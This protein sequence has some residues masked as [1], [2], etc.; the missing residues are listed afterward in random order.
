MFVLS[1]LITALASILAIVLNI[2]K[3]VL[4]IRVLI[5]WVS[6]NP[7]NPIVQLLYQVTEPVLEPLRRILP[8]MGMM[9]LSPIVAFMVIVFLQQFLI[10]TLIDIAYHLR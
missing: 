2:F 4:L 9:D 10:R 3:W 6:P 7:Y 5:S 8:S 1:N